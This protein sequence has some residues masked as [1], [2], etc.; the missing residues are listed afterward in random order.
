MH[1]GADA[2]A[3]VTPVGPDRVGVAVLSAQRGSFAEQLDRFP[4]VRALL[5][6]AE[7]RS[8]VR[9]AGPFRQRATAVARGRVAL[10]GDAAGYL[11]AITGEGLS[12]GL[13]AAAELVACLRADRLEDYPAAHRRV[14]WRGEAL[15]RGMLGA[16]R[17]PALRGLIVPV[18]A[19][20]PPAFRSAVR[21]L[22]R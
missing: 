17:V 1:W 12:L 15:T 16:A 11:D 22:A 4:A 20:V 2:E 21:L 7:P 8:G 14:T 9:G 19:A 10:V 5:G 13:A 18:A 3:Y 6:D